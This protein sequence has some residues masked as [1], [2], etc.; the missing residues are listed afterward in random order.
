VSWGEL[1]WRPALA[2]ALMGAVLVLLGNVSIL[3]A[4]PLSGLVYVV[5]LILLR[6]FSDEERTLF[7]NLLSSGPTRS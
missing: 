1:L 5:A 7:R 6:T 2:A 4:V 3:L